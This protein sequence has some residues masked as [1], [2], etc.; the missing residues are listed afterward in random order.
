MPLAF[1]LDLLNNKR[2]FIPNLYKQNSTAISALFG[3]QIKYI[4]IPRPRSAATIYE[5]YLLRESTIFHHI[6]PAAA[7]LYYQCI[8]FP[9]IFIKQ[10]SLQTKSRIGIRFCEKRVRSIRKCKIKNFMS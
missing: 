7:D 4:Y 8:Y 1:Q 3:R 10:H 5:A 2:R 6:R 9:H